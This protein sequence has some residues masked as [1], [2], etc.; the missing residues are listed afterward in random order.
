[1]DKPTGLGLVDGSDRRPRPAAPRG[2][3]QLLAGDAG[4]RIRPPAAGSIA[5][6][7]PAGR[8]ARATSTMIS[9]AV[10]DGA[11]AVGDDQARASPTAEV[12]V[13]DRLGLG[14][15]RAGG[16]VEHQQ[17]RVADQRAGDLQP[18]PLT[19]GEVPGPL[20][21]GR[22]VTAPPAQQVAMDRGPQPR[23]DQP[24]CR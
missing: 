3:V 16:L 24:V 21:D 13:D 20:G 23:L 1:M 7:C 8:P 14:V 4:G 5:R 17:A 9:V 2:P 15:E 22:V 10:A 18:L 19:A 6:E 11:Q 12:V